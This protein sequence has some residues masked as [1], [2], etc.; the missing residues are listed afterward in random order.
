MSLYERIKD[1]HPIYSY[2]GP[3]ER[4]SRCACMGAFYH[5]EARDESHE[6]HVIE[7]FEK[8][9][10]AQIATDIRATFEDPERLRPRDPE[11]KYATDLLNDWQ[12]AARIAVEGVSK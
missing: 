1:E 8:A 9:L 10:R 2:S 4:V 6:L 3:L 12:W 7:E 11:G 5:W